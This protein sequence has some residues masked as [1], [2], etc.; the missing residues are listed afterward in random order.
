M[1]CN[2]TNTIW[3]VR[4]FFIG[5]TFTWLPIEAYEG[6]TNEDIQASFWCYLFG[7]LATGTIVFLADGYFVGGFLK[8]RVVVCSNSF[9]TRITVK[10]GD[11]FRQKGVKGI[12]VN[13][14][15][16][17]IVD[18][19]L[20]SRQSLHGQVIERFWQ[21]NGVRWQEQIYEDLGDTE[22]EEVSRPKG[23]SRR[24]AIGTTARA[25]TN[26][27]EF[28][29][30]A[31]SETDISNNVA[32]ATASSLVFSVR[33]LLQRAREVCAN[34]PIHLPLI[35]SGLSRVG[36]KNAVLV[37]L[38]ITAIVEET[39]AQKITDS[40]VLTLPIEKS[41]EIDLGEI[42]RSWK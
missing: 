13:N 6:V 8:R 30:V 19:D 14:F 26:G 23:N 16:D 35:G 33:K 29:F 24:Y 36:I 39:K 11:F 38:I 40:I 5:M 25:S 15:F 22:C 41:A 20:V 3:M 10:F 17:S 31:L 28:L 12:G 4:A 21:G 37:D 7:S 2:L 1:R 34:R 27:E 9:D 42:Q 32:Q 18:D